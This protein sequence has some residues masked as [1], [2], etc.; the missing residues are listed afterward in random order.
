VPAPPCP[1][2]WQRKKHFIYH[3]KRLIAGLLVGFLAGFF[4][5]STLPLAMTRHVLAMRALMAPKVRYYQQAPQD[6]AY[7][8][9]YAMPGTSD[10][11]SAL[12]KSCPDASAAEDWPWSNN[13]SG[14]G[15][16]R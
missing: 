16:R 2:L 14:R 9:W 12:P 13:D 5:G 4:V 7:G 8:S 6:R 15:G 1:S 3:H 11:S 10:S